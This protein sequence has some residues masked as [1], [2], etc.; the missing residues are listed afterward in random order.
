MVHAISRFR[1]CLYVGWTSGDSFGASLSDIARH[2]HSPR[3]Q[4]GENRM[5]VATEAKTIL[6]VGGAKLT[7][8]VGID[9]AKNATLPAMAAALLTD[10]ECLLENVPVLEDVLVM[11]D[12]LRWLG[13]DVD[14]D[15][16]GH[17]LR[18]CAR[19]VRQ[20]DAPADLV[21]KMR[22][23]FLVSGPL[24]SRFG[25]AGSTAPGGCKLGT[26]PVDVDLR[27]FRRMGASIEM[28]DA[29][30]QMTASRLYG[31]ELYMDYPSHTGTENLLMAATLARGT[32][33]IVNAASEPEIAFLGSLLEDMGARVRGVGTPHIRVDGV[34]RLRGYRAAILPDRIEAGTIA[35]AAAITDGEVI[36]DHVSENDM[37]PLTS[38]LRE[39]GAEVWWSAGSMLVRGRGT[40]TATEIQALPFPGFPTDLQAAFAVLMTQATGNSRVF[41]RVFNDRLRYAEQLQHMGADIRVIDKQ[42]AIISGPARLK[43]ADVYALDIRSGA[44]LVL[45][46]LVADGETRINEIQHLRRGY[47]DIVGKLH[48]LGA[49]IT[50]LESA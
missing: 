14:F 37:V 16:E 7:G 19:D 9:G 26:R 13:A 6:T 5:Q 30:Y 23:S 39:A 10:E 45:A 4:T 28:D 12:L 24:L 36:L 8:R 47:E 21:E 20:F 31:A 46:G 1:L 25:R 15:Q 27:G 43:G 42:Q 17:R 11:V 33:T 29:G 49:Q 48:S 18:I 38:K 44:C 2:G 50:Y 32:T 41:E 40:L 34:D 35:I 22:A 3:G